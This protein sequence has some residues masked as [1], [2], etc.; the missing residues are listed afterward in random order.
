MKITP[1]LKS[2]ESGNMLVELAI[3][4]PIFI[5]MLLA[6]S[7]FASHSKCEYGSII[8]SRF[9]TWGESHGIKKDEVKTTLK[10][11]FPDQEILIS[12]SDLNLEDTTAIGKYGNFFTKLTGNLRRKASSNYRSKIISDDVKIEAEYILVSGRRK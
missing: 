5:V 11:S 10:A 8:A 6:I 4:L 1:L 7:D 3:V 9:A 2:D 12:D